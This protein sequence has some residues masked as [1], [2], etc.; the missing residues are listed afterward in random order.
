M[1]LNRKDLLVELQ[2]VLPGVET[3]NSI[4]NG[5][6]TFV[7]T[8]DGIF[9]YNDSI[10]V[11]TPVSTGIEGAIKSKEFFNL[12]SK[13]KGEEITIIQKKGKLILKCDN[14]RAD[15]KLVD[16]S[17]MDYLAN[18]KLNKLKW[19]S[20]EE[21]F[22]SALSLCKLQTSASPFRGIYVNK[23][24]MYSTDEIRIA[25]YILE[26]KYPE[27]WM[28]DSSAGELLRLKVK[29]TS[30][31]TSPGWVHFKA[32]DGTMFSCKTNDAAQYPFNGLL[33]IKTDV[34]Q[35]KD[36]PTGQLPKAFKEAVDRVSVLSEDV[37]GF[38]VIN[39]SLTQQ[40]LVLFSH[41]QAGSIEEVVPWD[42]SLDL[43]ED[44]EIETAADAGF[45]LEAVNK[46][47]DFYIANRK[48][49][50]YLVFTNDRFT[51]LLSAIVNE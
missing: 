10:S 1:K 37:Q 12:L 17:I 14:V 7:F 45:L 5:A 43:E 8:E 13:L 32:K 27:F 36:D 33:K 18:L 39:L 3:G 44:E 29:L 40:D 28:D 21:G 15:I 11:S 42:K 4:L 35:T 19:L 48:S 26:N 38:S 49:G 23:D 47:L 51:L 31:A 41:R 50:Q 24:V 25:S 34:D 6:D 22:K 30:L 16:S 46:S 9:T 2:K 20:L